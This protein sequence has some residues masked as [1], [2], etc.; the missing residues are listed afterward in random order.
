MNKAKAESLKKHDWIKESLSNLEVSANPKYKIELTTNEL[1]SEYIN[2]K[3]KVLP[4]SNESDTTYIYVFKVTGK[5]RNVSKLKGVLEIEKKQQSSNSDEKNDL[6]R[7]NNNSSGQYVYVGRSFD[8]RARVR[9][10]LSSGYRGTYALHLE[11]WSCELNEKLEILIY[12]F[13][14]VNNV[15]I[16]AYEDALWDYL[17]PCFGRKGDK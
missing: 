4:T 5:Q 16:Q 11:R 13:N 2:K 7:I 15:V 3:V 1:D 12:E 9:Q 10:H 14:A 6:P 17:K 8:I